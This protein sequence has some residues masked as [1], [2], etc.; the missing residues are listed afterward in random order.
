MSIRSHL[1][2]LLAMTVAGT[3]AATPPPAPERE[4]TEVT[5]PRVRLVTSEGDIVVQLDRKR[6]PITVENFLAYAKADHYDGTI[7]HRVVKDFVVQT[8]G[9]GTDFEQRE[10]RE[11]IV[12]ESGNGL[13]NWRGTIAM[14]RHEE[15]HSATS[16]FYINLDDNDNLDPSV[17]R[18]G[19]CVFGE[20]IEGMDVVDRIGGKDTAPRREF[21]N[22]PVEQVVLKD[23]VLLDE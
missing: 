7:F 19:Y 3:A 2:A 12:N 22:M 5:Y 20:V 4:T 8:G 23:V 21:E 18:W 17:K 1:I 13:P 9:Y 15:P 14:A 10:T 6:A 11:P 16:Q